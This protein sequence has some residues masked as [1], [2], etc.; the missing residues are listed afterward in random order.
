MCYSA[1]V[2]ANFREYKR[3]TGAEMDIDQF[4]EIYGPRFHGV[5]I[6]IPRGLDRN[7][8]LPATPK[9]QQIKDLIDGYRASTVTRLEK[10]IFV[11]KKRLAD[12]ERKLAAKQTKAACESQRIATDKI[13]KA[14]RDL[15]LYKGT[16]PTKLDD[17]IFPFHYAPIVVNE[18][19]KNVIKLAR[20]HLRQP[21]KPASLD[22]QFPG[23]YNARRD[24]L[25]KFWRK[26]FTHSHALMLVN[27]FYENVDRAGRNTVLHFQP[28]PANTMLIACLYAQWSDDQGEKL[29]SFAA[30][31]DEPPAEVA[32]AG[33]DRMIINIKPLNIDA[34]LT[35]EGRTADELQAIL[36]DRQA[37][38]YEHEVL[39]A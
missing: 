12:A 31:T 6:R 23:L 21:G 33:H 37:P 30:I 27:S 10:E 16:Q 34:W 3:M 9:V 2:E 35:P 28:R 13:A 24:N 29:L 11:Q 1:Q 25:E 14:L 36:S 22:R 5:N 32:A 19:G 38:Y 20:Y 18:G 4:T 15:P 26:E 8:D 7:F 17:R 39:A